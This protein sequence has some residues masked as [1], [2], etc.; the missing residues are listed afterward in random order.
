VS[1]G[2]S[3]DSGAPRRKR[4]DSPTRSADLDVSRP[5]GWPDDLIAEIASRQR[6]LITRRELLALGLRESAVDHSVRRGRLIRRHQGVYAVGGLALPPFADELA[7]VLAVGE[8]AYLSHSSAAALWGMVPEPP[9]IVQVTLIGRDAGR[10]RKGIEVHLTRT[11]DHRDVTTYDGIPVTRPARVLLDISPRLSDRQLERTF[12]RGLKERRFSRHA[13]ATLVARNPRRP[14]AARL[15]A[16]A[17]AEGRFSTLTRSR[18][19]ETLLPL[20]RAGGLPEPEVN[21]WLGP[22]E[23]D[24]LWR[25]QRLVVQVDG[26]EFHSTRRSFEAD[27]ALD[28]ELESDGFVVMRFTRDQIEKQP[29]LVLVKLA[30][31][32]DQLRRSS[33]AV[34]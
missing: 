27:H 21:G 1:P 12:D 9:R 6:S 7:A 32:L 8:G 34:A 10:R 11:M 17:E 24:F 14:G 4:P 23:I 3:D 18:P 5:I 28:L 16:L 15:G 33:R 26:Y 19:E 13:V 25:A 29:E 20:I 30:Q 31:R 22:H 2:V